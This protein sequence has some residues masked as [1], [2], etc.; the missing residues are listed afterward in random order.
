MTKNDLFLENLTLFTRFWPKA[1]LTL[2][3]LDGSS[4]E[5]CYTKKGEL[6]L[7]KKFKDD[8]FYHSDEGAAEE[9]A[10]WLEQNAPL[11]VKVLFI[12][13]IGLGYYYDVL[14]D[15][16]K[17]DPGR[18]LIFIEDD[19]CVLKKFLETEKATKILQDTQVIIHYFETPNERGWGKFRSSFQTYFNAFSRVRHQIS[20]LK[21][22]AEERSVVW[23]LIFNQIKVNMTENEYYYGD[24]IDYAASRCANFYQNLTFIQETYKGER[25]FDEFSKIP[26]LICGAGPSIASQIEDIKNIMH[27]AII[28]ASGT[29]VNVL[30]N[31]GIMPHFGACLDPDITQESRFLTNYA[32]EV[33][34]FYHNRFYADAARKIHGP[35]LLILEVAGALGSEWFYKELGL[36][37]LT[38]NATGI[39]TSNFCNRLAG[40]LK[41]NPIIFA[42]LDLAYTDSKRYA[43]GVI[44]HPTDDRQHHVNIDSHSTET[45]DMSNQEGKTKWDWVLEASEI[46]A[47]SHQHPE[48]EVINGTEGGMRILDIPSLKL[49][50]IIGKFL[51]RSYDLQN[52]IH[53]I[54]QQSLQN[55]PQEALLRAMETW[56]K[57][58]EKCKKSVA[59]IKEILIPIRDSHLFKK[60]PIP[61]LLPGKAVLLQTDLEEEIAYK[62]VF[63]AYNVIFNEFA[64]PELNKLTLFPDQFNE[65]RRSLWLFH[66]EIG[67]FEFLESFIEIHCSIFEKTL[68]NYKDRLSN[69]KKKTA[70][71]INIPPQPT[72]AAE[73]VY[74][75]GKGEFIIKDPELGINF[76]EAFEPRKI[77]VEKINTEAAALHEFILS[78]PG[79]IEGQ[80]LLLYSNCSVEGEMYY[81]QGK[82][83]GPTSFYHQDGTLLARSWF[84]NDQ[85]TG[86][87]W[88]Y[89]STGKVY[90][91][92]K[93]KEGL[94]HGLQAYY[95]P[96]GVLKSSLSYMEGVF[97]GKICLYYPDGSPKR[98]L[99]F[100]QGK[101]HGSELMWNEEG[102]KVLEAEYCENMPI[103]TSKVWHDNGTLA[104]Q[105]EFHGNSKDF[106]ISFWNTEGALTEK[107]SSLSQNP[108]D[109]IINKSNELKKMLEDTT[110][111][112]KT[113]QSKPNR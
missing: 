56:G 33:P 11:G 17:A 80:S 72:L 4:L 21:A 86:K 67:R 70:D 84:V 19:L 30:N 68:Q 29:A 23:N 49:K 78:D 39:S 15:W 13:G 57:S 65:E 90:S 25:F 50:D 38:P 22:Y 24:M 26:A 58:L 16:L 53:A 10:Q 63:Y 61:T 74:V 66:R 27:K 94:L 42:G 91:L 1:A 100:K 96:S 47:F 18:Y 45:I 77:P 107:K 101:L 85:E 64:K 79:E 71:P 35:R 6:N 32:Y 76:K 34:F 92:R 83:H 54:I 51:N 52:W 73:D 8:L 43:E 31:H 88:Q 46:T 60:T 20:A 102:V 106:D 37:P 109:M 75:F 108:L 12:F 93:F 112:F 36:A 44:A 9:A 41:C 87:S 7:K 59:A 111:K 40:N 69:S 55:I 98:F 99:N 48:V 82:L 81:R 97:H 28:F 3:S 104:K 103:G 5:F 105:I 89:Y 113:L 95:Y 14:E 110:L 62:H 2:E